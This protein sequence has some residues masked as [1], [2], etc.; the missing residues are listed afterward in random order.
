MRRAFILLFLAVLVFSSC[1]KEQD[2]SSIDIG[3]RYFP[4]TVGSFITYRVDST[5]Y[6]ITQE[7]YQYQIK[8]EIVDEFVDASGQS[9]KVLNRYY[10]QTNGDTW[11]LIDV[12]TQKRTGTTAERVEENL[13]FVKLEFPVAEG[14]NWNGNAF[15]NLGT[16]QYKYVNVGKF[17]D[18]GILQFDNTITVEQK[19][20]VNLVDEEV[21]YE[22]YAVDIGLVLR[23][24]TDLDKQVG[25]TSG[26]SVVY[27]AIGYS[28]E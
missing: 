28:I 27:E 14:G 19:N 12:W 13:R 17:A 5:W 20:N 10:R 15:N 1:E 2:L 22:I 24:S 11:V 7:N 26:Y 25:Q 23:H 16:Q 9:A 21:F 18:V 6:G 3:Y 8:E 4:L